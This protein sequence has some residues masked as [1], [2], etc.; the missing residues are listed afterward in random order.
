MM[1]FDEERYLSYLR[2][3]PRE[4]RV[5]FAVACAERLLPAYRAYVDSGGPGNYPLLQAAMADAWLWTQGGVP[6]KDPQSWIDECVEQ[7]PDEDGAPSEVPFSKWISDALDCSSAVVYALRAWASGDPQE[8]LWAAKAEHTVMFDL[9][10]E[11]R[12]I[13][14]GSGGPAAVSATEEH[15]VV[16]A[17][18]RRHARDLEELLGRE[19]STADLSQ[20]IRARAIADSNEVCALLQRRP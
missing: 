20:R 3:L 12:D 4:L 1:R 19:T 7:V 18:L 14:V 6:E 2:G 10:E 5:V 16:Q 17:E 15:P 8:A 9:A 13:R 11:L